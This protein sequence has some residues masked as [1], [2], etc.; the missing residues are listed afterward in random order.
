MPSEGKCVPTEFQSFRTLATFVKLASQIS[1]L[2]LSEVDFQVTCLDF[3][4]N[5]IAL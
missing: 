4:K 3:R 5:R 2:G 1:E